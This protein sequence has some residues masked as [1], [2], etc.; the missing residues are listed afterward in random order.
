MLPVF[1][2]IRE[3]KP[4]IITYLVNNGQPQTRPFRLGAF[5]EPV[6]YYGRI[7]RQRKARIADLQCTFLQPDMNAAML[8]VVPDGIHQQIAQ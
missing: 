2:A 8:I 7:K 3:R 4:I 5:G 6:K 1:V